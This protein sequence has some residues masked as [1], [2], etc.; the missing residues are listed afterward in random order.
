LGSGAGGERQQAGR[1]GLGERLGGRPTFVRGSKAG[2]G[3]ASKRGARGGG[4][5]CSAAEVGGDVE[6]RRQ[7][8]AR[9]RLRRELMR[10]DAGEQVSSE[11]GSWTGMV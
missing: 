1:G 9:E 5:G 10:R 6:G 4:A 2:P 7:S 8:R 11:H 3:G